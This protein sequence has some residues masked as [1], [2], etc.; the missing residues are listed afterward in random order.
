MISIV[1]YLFE[2]FGIG[3]MKHPIAKVTYPAPDKSKNINQYNLN[4]QQVK[5]QQINPIKR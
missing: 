5:S 4:K 2:D 3:E 1:N